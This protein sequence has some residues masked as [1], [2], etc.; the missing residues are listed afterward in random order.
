MQHVRTCW[1]HQYDFA[2]RYVVIL[3]NEVDELGWGRNRELFA[4]AMCLGL[5]LAEE[6]RDVAKNSR[7]ELFDTWKTRE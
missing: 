5:H 7:G 3:S 6:I 1:I 2:D 4:R